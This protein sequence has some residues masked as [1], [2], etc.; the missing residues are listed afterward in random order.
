[1]TEET[2]LEVT[3]AT[4]RP[5]TEEE[6][7][8]LREARRRLHDQVRAELKKVYQQT[9]KRFKLNPVEAALM[10]LLPYLPV[11]GRK[12]TGHK[13]Y[14]LWGYVYWSRK[15]EIDAYF[16]ASVSN[17]DFAKKLSEATGGI[18]NEQSVA[19]Q[20]RNLGLAPR[21][22]PDT[23]GNPPE[24]PSHS[25]ALFNDVFGRWLG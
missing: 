23:F 19:K 18:V 3:S 11:E 20:C 16:G 6:L 22:K 5:L 25:I 15:P 12:Q 21:L 9:A 4:P 2:I 24:I 1:M 14:D 8:R 7:G 17:V 13:M 10:D